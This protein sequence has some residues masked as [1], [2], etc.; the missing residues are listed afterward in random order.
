MDQAVETA[1][2]NRPD[3]YRQE[4]EIRRQ[5]ELLQIARSR[6]LPTISG[7][8]DNTWAKP[9]PKS[10]AT[11]EI[12][13]GDTWVAGIRGQWSIFDGFQREGEI[14]QQRAQLRQAQIG[15]IDTEEMATYEL[16]QALLTMENAAEFVVSQRLNLTRATEQLRLAEVGYAQG[17]RTAFELIETRRGVTEARVNYFQAIHAHVVAKLALLRAMGTILER[18]SASLPPAES[19]GE[20]VP[21]IAPPVQEPME[22][23]PPVQ[24][25]AVIPGPAEVEDK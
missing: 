15:L 4:F 9:D 23:E 12:D 5:K 21:S 25:P 7:F 17:V 1:L 3:L 22:V 2:K 8:F 18:D 24:P 6:Y 10:F 14:I 13:W 20:A 19:T 16:T 11:T